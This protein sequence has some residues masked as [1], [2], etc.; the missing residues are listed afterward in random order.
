L[1]AIVR[2]S[3]YEALQISGFQAAFVNQLSSWFQL[4]V[5]ENPTIHH[6]SNKTHKNNGD[7]AFRVKDGRRNKQELAINGHL[8]F[9][10]F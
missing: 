10:N 6:L 4:E 8:N 1:D 5:I 3:E 2:Y 9:I 7:R